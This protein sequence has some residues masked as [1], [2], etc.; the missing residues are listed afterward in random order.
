[1]TN[2]I[3]SFREMQDENNLAQKGLSEDKKARDLKR[4]YVNTQVT[5]VTWIME[6]FINV[7]LVPI[8]MFLATEY[9]DIIIIYATVCYLI[10][11]PYVFLMNTSDNKKLVIDNGWKNT[12]QNALGMGNKDDANEDDKNDVVTTSQFRRKH[13]PPLNNQEGTLPNTPTETEGS[14]TESTSSPGEISTDANTNNRQNML[15]NVHTQVPSTSSGQLSSRDVEVGSVEEQIGHFQLDQLDATMLA[16]GYYPFVGRHILSEM[17]TNIENEEAYIKLFRQ[18]IDLEQSFLNT[19]EQQHK[20]NQ[21]L[22]S[23]WKQKKH[24]Y[25]LSTEGSFDSIGPPISIEQPYEMEEMKMNFVGKKHD[26]IKLRKDMLHLAEQY[27]ADEDSW[28]EYLEMLINL[29]ESLVAD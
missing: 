29:E 5:F 19:Q 18:L 27:Y 7:S 21:E 15:L 17:R 24:S 4:V 23:E 6:T 13:P 25:V 14:E 28:A 9:F 8:C 16:N 10:I 22:F 12:F 1:M 20:T 3:S 11:L 26:R 2:N